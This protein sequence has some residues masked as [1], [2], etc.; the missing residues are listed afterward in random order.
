VAAKY[1][2]DSLRGVVV[3]M[4]RLGF[5]ARLTRRANQAHIHI[6]AE[7]IEPAPQERQRALLFSAAIF[8]KSVQSS[9]LILL[10]FN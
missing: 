7:I 4:V 2:I 6:V 3:S 5:C 1:I 9:E 8:A 10:H